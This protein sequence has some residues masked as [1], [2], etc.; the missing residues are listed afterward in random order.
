MVLADCVDSHDRRRCWRNR[1]A[2]LHAPAIHGAEQ[3]TVPT[4]APGPRRVHECGAVVSGRWADNC[5]QFT[6]GRKSAHII[7]FISSGLKQIVT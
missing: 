6:P 2:V 1:S 4:S 7:F 5:G 3:E